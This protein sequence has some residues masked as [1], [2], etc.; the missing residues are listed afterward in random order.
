MSDLHDMDDWGYV[1]ATVGANDGIGRCLPW[2][3]GIL[4]VT[5]LWPSSAVPRWSHHVADLVERSIDRGEA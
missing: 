1:S 2:T 4:R 5:L 3:Y